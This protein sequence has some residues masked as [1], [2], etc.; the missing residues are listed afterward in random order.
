MTNLATYLND[1]L[2]G[3]VGALELLDDLI[4]SQPEGPLRRFL[5]TLRADIEADQKEPQNLMTN[6]GITESTMRKAG[7]WVAEKVSR[8][9]LGHGG[10]L[11][12]LALLQ[13]LEG[14][15][16]GIAGKRS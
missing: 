15:S 7:A 1:H 3:S 2:A 13:S 9:K 12:N 14:L 10:G 5:Q 8:L 11:P 16:I 6:L 4:D